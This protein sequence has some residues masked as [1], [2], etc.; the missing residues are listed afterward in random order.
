MAAPPAPPD[1]RLAQ[2]SSVTDHAERERLLRVLDKAEAK[3]LLKSG[4]L[5]EKAENLQLEHF[6]RTGRWLLG[7][8]PSKGWY[9]DPTGRY[10]F[11]E[12]LG[13]NWTEQVRAVPHGPN[14]VD[15]DFPSDEDIAA[16]R[17][18]QRQ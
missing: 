16:H 8:P 18:Q 10:A 2:E 12:W 15:P 14:M 4:R 17:R 1:R 13:Y 3:G 6:R 7:V 5:Y 9:P 11:R